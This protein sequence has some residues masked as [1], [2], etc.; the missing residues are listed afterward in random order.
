MDSDDRKISQL[1]RVTSLSDSD[2]LVV[3]VNVGTAPETKAIEKSNAIS[4]GTGGGGEG[5]LV[6]GVISVTVASNNLTVAIKTLAGANPSAGDPVSIQIAGVIH[7]I[8]SALSVT[9]NAATNWA[10][11]GGAMFAALE[12]DW[13]V[14]LGYNATDGITIGF[15]PI[16]YADRYSQFSTT[17][18]AETYCKISVITNAAAA[19]P[20]VLIGRFGAT[21]SAAA[22]HVWTVPTF[23]PENLV[24]RP[25][26]NTRPRSWIPQFTNLTLGNGT[27][28]AEYYINQHETFLNWSL[29]FGST[30][31]ISGAVTHTIPMTRRWAG[32]SDRLTTGLVRFQDTGT[33]AYAGIALMETALLAIVAQNAS[34]TYLAQAVLSS[35]IPFTWTTSDVII[36]DAVRYLIG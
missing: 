34:G 35:S 19:D 26:F 31:S 32:S 33:A 2:L 6:N 9:A 7:E 16:P 5:I 21:L 1:S 29:I 17:S 22:G 24:Q 15:S 27:L 4:G 36:V 23:T 8:T 13:F 18:T 12:Q 25:I 10:G 30:T 28:Y 11:R 20:Y 14:Y 3:V